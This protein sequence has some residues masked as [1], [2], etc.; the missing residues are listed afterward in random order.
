M[1][2]YDLITENFRAELFAEAFDAGFA[3]ARAEIDRR[4]R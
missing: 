1:G 2:E 3:L 4:E